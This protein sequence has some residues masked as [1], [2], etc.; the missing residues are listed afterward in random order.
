MDTS[1]KLKNIASKDLVTVNGDTLVDEF[2]Y[3]FDRRSI[4][5]ILVVNQLGELQG[6]ISKED[7][8]R[9]FKF[10][11]EHKLT[12]ADIMTEQPSYLYEEDELSSAIELF[13]I[14]KFRAIP[15]MDND[16][17]LV[18]IITPYDILENI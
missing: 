3:H 9:D 18:G 13:L 7:V 8:L 1:I 11:V 2:K 5:H 16:L 12:A 15:I 4:H 14:N 10:P 17:S 6:I